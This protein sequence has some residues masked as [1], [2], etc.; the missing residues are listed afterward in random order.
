VTAEVCGGWKRGGG[1]SRNP[2]IRCSMGRIRLRSVLVLTALV[3]LS[4][5]AGM[6]IERARARSSPS[7]TVTD[8]SIAFLYQKLD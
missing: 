8:S 1:G 7:W 6:Q 4:L 5:W 2:E 3:A